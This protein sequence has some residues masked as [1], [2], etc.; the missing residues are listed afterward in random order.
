MDKLIKK[1]K[2]LTYNEVGIHDD[3]HDSIVILK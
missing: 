2:R 3:L 1:Q